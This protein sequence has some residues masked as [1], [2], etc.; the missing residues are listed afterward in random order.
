[1]TPNRQTPVVLLF[2]PARVPGDTLKGLVDVQFPSGLLLRGIA[3]HSAGSRAWCSPPTPSIDFANHGVRHRWS[4]AILAELR[5]TNPKIF[6]TEPT[7]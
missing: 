4:E 3:V 7:S 6:A 1:M 5:R 2:R